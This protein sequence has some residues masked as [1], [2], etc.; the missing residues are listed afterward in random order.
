MN[1]YAGR[2]LRL[3]LSSLEHSTLETSRY[4]EW[5]G[6]HGIGSAIFFDLVPDKAIGAFDP[7][8]VVTIMTSPLTGTLAPATTRT[9]VQG[10]GA[11]PYPIEWFT[12]SN[13][14]GRFGT[15][16]KY[17]GWDGI[18][19][20]GKAAAPVWVDIRDHQVS[21][22][23]A[24][25]LWGLDTW[26]TQQEIWRRLEVDRDPRWGGQ[27]PAVLTIGPAGE[28]LSRMGTLIHDAGSA[29]G[30]GGFG[31][32]WGSKNLK[33]I[34]VVGT[35]S[36]EVADP[37]ALLEARSWLLRNYS[38][39]VD[40]PVRQSPRDNFHAYGHITG[41]PGDGPVYVP[42]T[43]P[44]RPLGC[45]SCARPCRRR[46]VSGA[47]NET[48]CLAS[49]FYTA[50]TPHKTLQATELVQRTG[51]NA[52]D[53]AYTH[54]YLRA[55]Y[56]MGVLGPGRE[57]ECDLPFDR[58][59]KLEFIEALVN[60]IAYRQGI[61]DDLAEGLARAIAK[62]GRLEQ[63]QSSGLVLFTAWGYLE[64]Y[65]PR[66][67]VEWTYGSILG[68][69][70]INEHCVNTPL[71]WMPTI[72]ALVGEEPV[73]SAEKLVE[74]VAGKLVPYCD[75]AMLDYSEDGVY[76]DAKVKLI[77]WHRHYTRFW[78]QS[79]LFCDVAFPDLFNVNTESMEGY[80]PE[81]EQRFYQAVTGT[82]M[83]FE[84]GMELGRKIWNLDRTIWVLQGR[85]R[86]LEVPPDY[87]FEVP[88]DYVNVL[89]T[90]E[91]GKWTYNE[92][93][94]RK[95]DRERFEDWKTRY[96]E[97]EGWDPATGWPLPATLE[98][99]GLSQAA[100]ELE[101][102]AAADQAQPPGAGGP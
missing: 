26:Q 34:S 90:R 49:M 9:E 83:T 94:G 53:L 67:A 88:T 70:D 58:Y 25:S 29:A 99:L 102:K 80:S 22:R 96:F 44:S 64:H 37:N 71:H 32:V 33:A 86:D 1:G 91:N 95:L 77:A 57:I 101:Q 60:A 45:T 100:R 69:R 76:A 56:K 68:D 81:A 23:S 66:V 2:I 72:T 82:G 19:I 39:N 42:V 6:G 4:Q 61:G 28:K 50:E 52:F 85:H 27:K 10:V 20:E 36:I 15:L 24:T 5:G 17:A 43:E 7:R 11:Q 62:W 30:Q 65:E 93:L 35:G 79:A 92:N 74:I 98:K 47:G 31:A 63:D 21:L 51:V 78:K 75:P 48:T 84:Q 3:H 46:T 54:E 59:G 18:V 13:F 89:P 73:V 14:G 87:V 97:F 41:S 55:L 8:N 12:R 40:D 38:Y 16:L